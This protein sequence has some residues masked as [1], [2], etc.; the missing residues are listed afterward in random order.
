MV[1]KRTELR[2]TAKFAASELIKS[3]LE[4]GWELDH[5]AEI[6]GVTVDQFEDEMNRLA[7]VLYKQSLGR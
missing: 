5:W 3:G 6:A 2:Q 7:E 4:S 1:D